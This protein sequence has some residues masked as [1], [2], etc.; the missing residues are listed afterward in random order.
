MDSRLLGND[1]GVSMRLP[2]R[3]ASRNDSGKKKVRADTRSAL[4]NKI[5]LNQSD[6]I[7]V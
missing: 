4:L 1:I 7:N 3:F 2:R 5:N 6:K